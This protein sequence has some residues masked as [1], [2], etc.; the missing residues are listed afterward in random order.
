MRPDVYNKGIAG[1]VFWCDVVIASKQE[2]DLG[3]VVHL[4]KLNAE[5]EG[6]HLSLAAVEHVVTVPP[7]LRVDELVVRC[8]L[9]GSGKNGG[10]VAA[11]QGIMAND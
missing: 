11:G 5:L 3:L 6:V 10:S 4:S 2:D 7:V 9:L 1:D 8:H